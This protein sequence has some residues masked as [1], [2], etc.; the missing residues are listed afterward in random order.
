MFKNR[1]VVILAAGAVLLVAAFILGTGNATSAVASDLSDYGLRHPNAAIPVAITGASDFIERHPELLK[2]GNTV[3][4]TD[5]AARHPAV[6]V[7]R[8]FPGK[9]MDDRVATTVGID[10]RFAGKAK[11]DVV[12]RASDASDWFE[13]HQNMLNAAVAA[14]FSNDY[15]QRHPE[16]LK[17]GNAVD[18]SDWFQRHPSW[19][20]N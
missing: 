9:E 6:A 12:A 18:L 1:L 13:R 3:D 4:L 16:T 20:T 19:T 8:S 11:D 2:P 5:Y 17:P 7:E 14:E 10:G 15:A